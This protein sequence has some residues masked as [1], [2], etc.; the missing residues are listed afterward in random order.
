MVMLSTLETLTLTRKTSRPF[1]LITSITGRWGL[2][3]ARPLPQE[4]CKLD[5]P[6]PHLAEFVEKG[7]LAHDEAREMSSV[8]TLL[9]HLRRSVPR[10]SSRPTK[11]AIA[12]RPTRAYSLGV[13]RIVLVSGPFI[14]CGATIAKHFAAMLEEHDLFVPD[15]DDD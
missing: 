13:L 2:D 6:L 8:S 10:R 7:Q 5:L 1:S 11:L 3:C 15:D 4:I 14:Y 9:T 12:P